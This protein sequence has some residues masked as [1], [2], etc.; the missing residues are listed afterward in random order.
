MVGICS[1][2]MFEHWSQNFV[3]LLILAPHR[4]QNVASVFLFES[5]RVNE[6]IPEDLQGN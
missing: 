1:D 3:E 2:L 6:A 4:R 5:G